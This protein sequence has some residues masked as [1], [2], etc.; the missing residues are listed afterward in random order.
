[1]PADILI[2]HPEL[3][4]HHSVRQLIT[5][6]VSETFASLFAPNPVPLDFENDDL[7]LAWVAARD[8]NILGVV[9]TEHD[10]V[11]DLWVVRE[12]RKLGVGGRLL[13]QGEAEI[14]ARGYR[15]CRLRVVKSNT[16]AVQF[17]LHRD[18]SI[19]REFPH[20]KFAHTMLEMVK[21]NPG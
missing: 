9:L 4:E 3:H 13:A 6:V 10:L 5:A 17:Y 12:S 1:M 18:W 20:E 19:A 7:S 11:S 15:A 2:R 8:S 14:A 16:V 21:S